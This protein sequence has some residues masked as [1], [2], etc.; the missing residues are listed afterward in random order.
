MNV[1]LLLL[2]LTLS[3]VAP[4]LQ[5]P[6]APPPKQAQE[7]PAQKESEASRKVEEA[8]SELEKAVEEAGNDRAALVRNLKEYL[9]RFPDAPRRAQVYRAIVEASL[10]LED[11]S[12]ALEYAERLIALRPEDSAMMLLAVDLLEERG[13]EHSLTKAVGYVSRVLDRVEKGPPA[14]EPAGV[15]PEEWQLEQKKLLM[16]VHLVRGRLE[17]ERRRYDAAAAD[18][19]ASYEVLPNGAAAMRLGE[20]A[21]MRKQYEKAVEHY[22]TAFVLPESHGA[23]ADQGEVRKKLGNVWKILHGSEA[24]LGERILAEYDRLV[25]EDEAGAAPELNANAKEFASFEVRRLTGEPLKLAELQGKVV[26]LNFWASWCLPCRELQP[27]IEGVARGFRD[28]AD[29]VFLA[30]NGDDDPAVMKAYV[31][32]NK[33]RLPVIFADGL[34]RF[35]KVEILPTLIVLDRNGKIIFRGEGFAPETV[36]KELAGAIE[37]TLAPAN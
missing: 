34:D 23:E 37:R 30:V 26:V 17:I 1:P 7:K 9:E 32:R 2:S 20:I 8:Q 21:E 29:V 33:M 28:N 13:D 3:G 4:A 22:L 12:G 15:S 11:T 14:K 19:Q 31:E 36:V 25:P 6:P 18:L 5:K 27:L 35:F 10:Q 24:G 16:S